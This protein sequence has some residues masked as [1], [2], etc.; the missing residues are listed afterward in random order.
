MTFTSEIVLMDQHLSLC[1]GNKF[2][3]CPPQPFPNLLQDVEKRTTM[4]AAALCGDTVCIS[5]LAQ[6][7][8]RGEVIFQKLTMAVPS[9]SCCG[10][11]AHIVADGIAVQQ[12]RPH[13][14]G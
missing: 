13:G 6:A 7:G 11:Q 5:A 12:R 8:A 10:P 3:P 14:P 4:L 9:P 1:L 2:M